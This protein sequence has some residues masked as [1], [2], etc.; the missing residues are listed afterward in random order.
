[1]SAVIIT[2]VLL[3]LLALGVA[4]VVV[5]G[6]VGHG[7]EQAPTLAHY[8]AKTARHLNGDGQAPAALNKLITREQAE[9]QRGTNDTLA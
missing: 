1:M 4:V 7:K 6:M 8:A 3:V 9:Q 2:M 5:M